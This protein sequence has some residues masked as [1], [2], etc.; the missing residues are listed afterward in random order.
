MRQK[1]SE[2]SLTYKYLWGKLLNKILANRTQEHIKRIISTTKWGASDCQ[3][4]LPFQRV[5][6]EEPS[7]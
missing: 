7:N 5:R 1:K 6:G 3:Y 2:A 4:N